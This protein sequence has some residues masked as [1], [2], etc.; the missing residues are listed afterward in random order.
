MTKSTAG[1]DAL[2]ATR[3]AAAIVMLG[4]LV[5]F[6]IDP[7]S[8]ATYEVLSVSAVGLLMISGFGILGSF[9]PSLFEVVE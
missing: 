8:T 1:E 3:Q 6:K 9:A 4:K 2:A 7:D 5:R